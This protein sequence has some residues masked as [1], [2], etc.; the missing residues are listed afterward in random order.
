M[1]RQTRQCP[2]YIKV[3]FVH[4]APSAMY[5]PYTEFKMEVRGDVKIELLRPSV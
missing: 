4:T 5:Y 1:G 2:G 3:R